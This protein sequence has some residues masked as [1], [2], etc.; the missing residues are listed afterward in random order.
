MTRVRNIVK[1][2]AKPGMAKELQAVVEELAWVRGRDQ[3][4]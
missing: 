4:Y 1:I 2:T 3:Q